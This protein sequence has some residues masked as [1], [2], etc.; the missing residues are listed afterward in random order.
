MQPFKHQVDA[1]YFAM[2]RNGNVFLKHSMGIG[3]T[4]AALMIFQKLREI[5]PD[6]KLIVLCPKKLIKNTWAEDIKKFT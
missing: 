5:H 4:R 2:L 1:V 3:K 6:L